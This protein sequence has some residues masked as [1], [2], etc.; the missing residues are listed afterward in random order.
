MCYSLKKSEAILIP[1]VH[2]I[3]EKNEPQ[4][5]QWRA[6]IVQP[7]TYSNEIRSSFHSRPSDDEEDR[8]LCNALP[9]SNSLKMAVQERQVSSVMCQGRRSHFT[10]V[11]TY[12]PRNSI[13]QGE[14]V[15]EDQEL[16]KQSHLASKSDPTNSGAHSNWKV[17]YFVSNWLE[18]VQICI[19]VHNRL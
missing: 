18:K 3:D 11:V 5:D 10:P 4:A 8:N 15:T 9:N 7:V 12:V 16:H 6:Q 14:Q 1:P 17:F 2:L 19:C 13:K